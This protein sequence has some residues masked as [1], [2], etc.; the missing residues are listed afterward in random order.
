MGLRLH[1]DDKPFGGSLSHKRICVTGGAGFIGSHL[2][3]S[4][5]ECGAH[6]SVIDDLSG[7]DAERLAGLMDRFPD[8]IRFVNGSI[9]DPVALHEALREVEVVYHLAAMVSVVQSIDDPDRCFAV[10]ADGTERIAEAA[11]RLGVE[12]WVL[13]SSCAV[14]GDR[15]AL[16]ICETVRLDPRSP[17]A[18]SKA[19]GEHIVRAWAE[20]YG[21]PGLSLRLFNVFG[22]GQPAQGAYAAMI[23]AFLTAL[24]IGESP[25]IYGDGSATRDLIYVQDVVRAML[26]AGTCAEVPSGQAINIGTGVSVS[27]LDVADRLVAM[28]APNRT[29]RFAPERSGEVRHSSADVA[30]AHRLLGFEAATPFDEALTQ[31]AEAMGCSRPAATQP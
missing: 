30:A 5:I 25:T 7:G 19:A 18:A 4:L 6:V 29:I 9:L 28:C 22:P 17:Y 10:N 3:E 24:R 15:A 21:L 13:A 16:P 27:V 20:S 11:R 26:L 23:P 1:N 14:Y 12:R 2:V 8:R 31:T